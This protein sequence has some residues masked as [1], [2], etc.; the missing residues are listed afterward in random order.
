MINKK[1]QIGFFTVL[2][3]A[4]LFLGFLVF[5]PYLT[6]LFLA[7]ILRIVF[8]KVHKKILFSLGGRNGLSA[9]V[10]V[11]TI[12]VFIVVPVFLISSLIFD[13]ARNLYVKAITG[14]IDF[15]FVDRVKQ[16]VEDLLQGFIPDFTINPLAYMR[17][18]LNFFLQNIGSVFSTA[19]TLF[20]D[21]FLMLLS[22]FYLFRDGHK[23]RKYIIFL[24]PL[25]DNY[26]ENIL[27]KLSSAVDGVVRGSLSVSLIQGILSSIGFSIFGVP[28]AFI[29]GAVAAVAALVPPF[30]TSAVLIPAVLYLFWSGS[31]FGAIGLLIWGMIAVGLVDNILSPYLLNRSLSV[32]PLLILISVLGGITFFGPIGFLAGPVL[33]T[34][35]TTLLEIYPQIVSGGSK[36]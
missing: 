16:P 25:Q 36:H 33:V 28:N 19:V 12:V 13:D 14:D 23:L 11:I 29:W 7:V 1:L 24:S 34:L 30:G 35:L 21:F 15:S 3:V 10:A 6:A 4:V 20:L 31:T 9:I 26:D 17:D 22:L 27:A 2:L 32:H 8:D 18:G 5:K